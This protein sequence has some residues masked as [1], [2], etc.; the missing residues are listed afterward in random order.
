MWGVQIIAAWREWHQAAEELRRCTGPGRDEVFR[1]FEE[2]AKTMLRIEDE[3][4]PIQAP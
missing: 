1:Y 2:S 4:T 3:L